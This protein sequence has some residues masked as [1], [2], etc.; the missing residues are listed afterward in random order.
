MVRALKRHNPNGKLEGE[1]PRGVT[2]AQHVEAVAKARRDGPPNP[3][4]QGWR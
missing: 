1:R 2:P 4:Y 3:S